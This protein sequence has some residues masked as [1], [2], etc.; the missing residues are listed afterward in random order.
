VY[1]LYAN[2]SDDRCR[3]VLGRDGA[4]KI[5]VIGLNP[6]TATQNKSDAT[7]A[8]VET[9]ARRSGHDGFV[10]LNLYPLRATDPTTL[11]QRANAR[12]MQRNFD[13]IEAIVAAETAPVLWAAWGAGIGHRAFLSSCACELVS[14]LRR[15]RPRWQRYGPPTADGHPRHP[16]RLSYGWRFAAFAA[17]AYAQRIGESSCR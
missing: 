6:S 10:M 13:A 5:L 9:V 7:A 12:Q 16:S 4:R 2:S 8:K 15:Y 14:R 17:D 11:P 3:F 1:D